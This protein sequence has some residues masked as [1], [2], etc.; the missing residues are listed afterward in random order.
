MENNNCRLCRKGDLS[1][2]ES[3]F[4]QRSGL[5]ITGIIMKVCPIT[6]IFKGDGLPEVICDECLEILLSTYE[7]QVTSK[8]SDI[9]YRHQ[10]M[11]RTF[12]IKQENSETVKVE[13][14]SG[15]ERNFNFD[16]GAELVVKSDDSSNPVYDIGLEA[17]TITAR[18]STSKDNE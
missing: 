11:K 17:S 14:Q 6:K 16:N 1:F 18:T 5:E 2:S 4:S 3:I 7:L 15:D 12:V 8:E 10:L 9:F 13:N